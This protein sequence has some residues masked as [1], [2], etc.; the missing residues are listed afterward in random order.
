[1]LL[2]ASFCPSAQ[3]KIDAEGRFKVNGVRR[4]TIGVSNLPEM[5][6]ERCN[7]QGGAVAKTC[8]QTCTILYK[9]YTFNQ[10]LLG[11]T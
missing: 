10:S 4:V 2:L 7:L 5:I 3:C 11:E 1:M 8:R 9:Y 6:S